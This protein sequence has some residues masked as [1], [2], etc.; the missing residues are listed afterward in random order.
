ME[1]RR[2]INRVEYKA[3]SVIVLCDTLEKIYVEVKNVSPLGM[4]IIVP[5]GAPD[6]MGQDLIIVAETLI[7]YAYVNRT[8]KNED[9]TTTAGIEA[10]KFTPEV[11]SYLFESIG[12]EE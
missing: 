11:L 8:E 7:M 3:K 10:K 4:G 1:E 12:G 2:Q 9:G 6:I 5:A